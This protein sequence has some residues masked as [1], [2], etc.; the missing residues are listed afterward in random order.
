MNSRLPVKGWLGC[1]LFLIGT[2]WGTMPAALR[3]AVPPGPTPAAD[4]AKENADDASNPYSV[5]VERNIFHLNPPPPPPEPEKPKVELPVV[6]ITGFVN[7]G[8][9]SKVLFLSQPKDKKEGPFYYSLAEGEKSDDGKFELVKIHPSQDEV[10]VI[11]AGVPVTLTV[12]DDSLGSSPAPPLLLWRR[13]GRRRAFQET[14]CRGGRC[15][16]RA[17]PPRRGFQACQARVGVVFHF[18]PGRGGTCRRNNFV[19]E[20]ACAGNGPALSCDTV[21][22]I[23]GWSSLVARQAHN[24]KVVGSN[25]A[26]ATNLPV[27]THRC[28]GFFDSPQI[29]PK[30][31]EPR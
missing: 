8:D 25:P 31:M 23:A 15:S 6:K 27:A 28:N 10:D 22:W 18:R 1:L 19:L 29:D 4:M 5:I 13:K 11:N 2:A 12:K 17:D 24:L 3:A 14:A 16:R 21:L 20:R 30:A 9:K 26:P 7:I